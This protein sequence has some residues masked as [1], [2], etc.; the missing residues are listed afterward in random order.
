MKK[1]K[2]KYKNKKQDT[3]KIKSSK[4]DTGDIYV[5]LSHI[6]N[7]LHYNGVP[8]DEGLIIKVKD[9]KTIEVD[10]GLSRC[11]CDG[12]CSKGEKQKQEEK[13]M[14]VESHVI[15]DRP[16]VRKRLPNASVDLSKLDV[17]KAITEEALIRCPECGQSHA[18]ITPGPGC[19]LLMIRNHVGIEYWDKP[20]VKSEFLYLY[21]LDTQEDIDNVMKPEDAKEIDYYN[22]LQNA[23]RLNTE[24][25]CIV[26]DDTFL[27]C[28]VCHMENIFQNWK[29][30]WKFP[31]EFFE[32]NPCPVCGKEITRVHKSDGDIMQCENPNCGFHVEVK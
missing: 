14:N 24:K 13:N 20:P 8:N 16:A 19:S 6:K 1:L 3:L 2:F 29:K 27:T 25:D 21:S 18:V 5:L 17:K 32:S 12:N 9:K 10:F 22:D 30:A 7:L 26:N 23:A 11:K 28:P 4:K 15:K 31:E